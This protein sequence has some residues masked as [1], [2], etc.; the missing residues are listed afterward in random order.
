[1]SGLAL[2]ARA[3]FLAVGTGQ[4]SSKLIGQQV[5][6]QGNKRITISTFDEVGVKPATSRVRLSFGARIA[7]A[8][9]YVHQALLVEHHLHT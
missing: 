8:T 2:L 3:T 5:V 9:G 6:W 7:N 4:W 1:M